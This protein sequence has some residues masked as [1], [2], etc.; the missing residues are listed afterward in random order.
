MHAI[1]MVQHAELVAPLFSIIITRMGTAKKLNL[2][3]KLKY[4]NPYIFAT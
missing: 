3:H 2:C 1:L 4:L